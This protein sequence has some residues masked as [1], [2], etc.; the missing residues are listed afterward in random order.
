MSE[1]EIVLNLGKFALEVRK[2]IKG[3]S[4]KVVWWLYG[5]DYDYVQGGDEGEE[6]EYEVKRVPKARQ[7]WESYV[8]LY[9][10]GAMQ[11]HM[12]GKAERKVGGG[13]TG[14]LDDDKSIQFIHQLFADNCSSLKIQC[15]LGYPAL[16]ER[17]KLMVEEP[18]RTA[19]ILFFQE[20]L[21]SVY[22]AIAG[23][24][25]E[26]L[27]EH[28][29]TLPGKTEPKELLERWKEIELKLK[30]EK[31]PA[32][33]DVKDGKFFVYEKVGKKK[34]LI[35][36]WLF[37]IKDEGALEDETDAKEDESNYVF[38][39]EN[40]PFHTRMNALLT[41]AYRLLEDEKGEL[42]ALAA[43]HQNGTL[44]KILSMVQKFSELAESNMLEESQ[45]PGARIIA[46]KM[47]KIASL[48]SKNSMIVLRIGID[49]EQVR[50]CSI[51][52]QKL[53]RKL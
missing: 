27:I 20:Y 15:G 6:L 49:V 43:E 8:L 53:K 2:E 18:Q 38:K 44:N 5:R 52:L 51:Q 40:A 29:E 9:G 4:N 36:G 22:R 28:L 33:Y 24:D 16:S 3:L 31:R 34:R 14:R 21:R 50:N 46:D 25:A 26:I 48:V 37:G 30:R 13:Y 32:V 12:S 39:I 1:K 19:A 7:D 42:V 17:V 45:K 10:A 23:A 35:N 41:E 11:G 47:E